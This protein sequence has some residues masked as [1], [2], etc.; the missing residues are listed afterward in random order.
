MLVGCVVAGPFADAGDGLLGFGEDGGEH[1][2]DVEHF[3]PD[4]F[5]DF[6]AGVAGFL[7]GAGGVGEEHFVVADLHEERGEAGVVGVE[8]GGERGF[9]VG[10]AE[11][12]GGHSVDAAVFADHGVLLGAGFVGFAGDGEVGPGGDADA[13]VGQGNAA[14]AGGEQGGEGEA[15]AGGVAAD[16]EGVGR[17]WAV[18]AVGLG[19]LEAG[20][21]VVDGG[22]EGVFGGE[23]VVEVEHGGLG[24]AGDFFAEAAVGGAGADDVAA[25]VDVDDAAG[26][27]GLGDGDPF[28]GDA[29]GVDVDD[30]GGVGGGEAHV[31]VHALAEGVDAGA[32]VEGVGVAVGG[33][34]VEHFLEFL[35]SH[36]APAFRAVLGK[37]GR[38]LADA[39]RGAQRR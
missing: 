33:H 8:G 16:E 24:G 38:R 14:L 31:G 29:V 28:G 3:V 34:E 4:F 23:A 13:A 39:A 18:G 5:G 20:D 35:G 6:D 32:G 26:G 25:A 7:G 9:G 36:C 17:G 10:A 21:G 1:V 30:G 12:H 27:V 19:E 22:G 37:T 2:P 11:V 15:A